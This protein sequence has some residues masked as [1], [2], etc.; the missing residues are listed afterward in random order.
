MDVNKRELIF[1]DEVY[2]IIGAAMEVSTHLGAGFLEAVYQE[3]L[4]LEFAEQGIVFEPQKRI[5]ISYKG[6]VLEKEYI[7]DFL[8]YT[9]IVVEIKAIKTFSS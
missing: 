5:T 6:R 3:A 8:C 1:R 7:A 2:R 9:S 4:A